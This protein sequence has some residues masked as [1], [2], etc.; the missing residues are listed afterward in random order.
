MKL[1]NKQ[2][3][4]RP[5]LNNGYT[6]VQKVSKLSFIFKNEH[7]Y[8]Y[9]LSNMNENE[10]NQDVELE[11]KDN[12]EVIEDDV[13][14]DVDNEDDNDG[15]DWK[16]TAMRYKKAYKGLKSKP[17]K[18]AEKPS[19]KKE[20]SSRLE[21]L[22]LKLDGY[23]DEIIDEILPLGGKKFLETTIG[24]R[25]VKDIVE[26]SKAETATDIDS[27]G[28]SDVLKKYSE[29]ELRKMSSSELEKIIRETR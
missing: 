28:K 23:S 26:Q 17:E 7:Y 15:I 16:A 14:T 24:K 20:D 13:D 9:H 11:K 3:N 25:L 6:S 19:K 27:S 1:P 29:A 4:Q 10:F 22:E 5:H 18:M 2:I 12:E 21:R 8:S